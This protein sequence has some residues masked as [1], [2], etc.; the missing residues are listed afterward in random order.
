LPYLEKVTFEDVKR[1]AL[2]NFVEDSIFIE[3]LLPSGE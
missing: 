3:I 2:E 1:F